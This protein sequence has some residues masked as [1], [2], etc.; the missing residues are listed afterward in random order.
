MSGLQNFPINAGVT[1]LSLGVSAVCMSI[2]SDSSWPLDCSPP[3]S[4]VHGIILART[5][6][7]VAIPFS[8]GSSQPRD[9]TLISC[10]FALAG[11]FFTTEPCEKPVCISRIPNM[12]INTHD[13]NTY[14]S[15]MEI[16]DFSVVMFTG[17]KVSSHL[18]TI[19]FLFSS[20]FKVCCKSYFSGF[21]V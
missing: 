8:K 18:L 7:W 13:I 1:F 12:L 16:W 17:L 3:G 2:V 11:G 10:G 21:G 19:S 4:S 6:E 14:L 15:D 20:Y 9:Q 5:V